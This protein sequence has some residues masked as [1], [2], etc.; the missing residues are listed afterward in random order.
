MIENK[1]YSSISSISSNKSDA[2]TQTNIY[3]CLICYDN[4]ADTILACCNQY[5]HRECLIEWWRN[6]PSQTNNCPHCRQFVNISFSELGYVYSN[7]D[8]YGHIIK[9]C[10]IMSFYIIVIGFIFFTIISVVGS[11]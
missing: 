6:E 8:L 11:L 3:R 1:S 4:D 9:K 10:C 5:I 7:D 2:S